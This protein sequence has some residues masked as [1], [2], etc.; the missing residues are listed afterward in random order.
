MLTNYALL[1]GGFVGASD[2]S[3]LNLCV[4]KQII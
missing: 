1:G 3:T 4:I 2:G